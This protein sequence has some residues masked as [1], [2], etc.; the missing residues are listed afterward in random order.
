LKIVSEDVSLN[1]F[2]LI[3]VILENSYFTR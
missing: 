3:I 2:I 1:V